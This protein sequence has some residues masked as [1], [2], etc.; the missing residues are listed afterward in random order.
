M[1]EQ[2][3]ELDTNDISFE[4]TTIEKLRALK[5]G[6]MA[7]SSFNP[8][9]FAKHQLPSVKLYQT[10]SFTKHQVTVSG[11]NPNVAIQP[12]EINIDQRRVIYQF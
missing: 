7:V 2:N 12:K 5:S 10:S 8:A 6:W 11:F 1:A 9:S 4:L 3:I